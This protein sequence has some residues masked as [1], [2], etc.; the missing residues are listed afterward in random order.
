MSPVV[1]EPPAMNMHNPAMSQMARLSQFSQNSPSDH[2]RASNDPVS[3]APQSPLLTHQ[4][5]NQQLE[6]TI[7]STPPK[8]SS[9]QIDPSLITPEKDKSARGPC[10]NCGVMDTPLWRR[11]A[12]GNP[13]CNACGL[14]QK[15]RRM[16]R[17][18]PLGRTPPPSAP[19]SQ[20]A[21]KPVTHAQTLAS[22]A[23]AKSSSP[24]ANG[25]QSPQGKSNH[26][27]GTCPGDG[28]CDGTGGSSA[29]NGCPTYNNTLAVNARLEM[30]AQEG[31]GGDQVPASTT[32]G[33]ES[34]QAPASPSHPEASSPEAPGSPD[35]SQ[36]SGGPGGKK[37]RAAVG[38]LSCFNCATSTTPLWR[39]DDV[40]NNICNACGLYY[41]L[42]GTHRPGT[43]KK[44]VI[45][46]RKRVPAAPGMGGHSGPITRMTDQAAAEGLVS[47]GRFAGGSAPGTAGEESDADALEPP[48][49]RRGR[50]SRTTA[51]DKSR[52]DDDVA[53]EGTEEE[54]RESDRD[55]ERDSRRKKPKDG[56]WIEGG[57]PPSDPRFAHLQRPGSGSGYAGSPHL[58]GLDLPP[59]PGLSGD[60]NRPFLTPFAPPSSFIRSGSAAPSRTHS[61]M[62]PPTGAIHLGGF[63]PP[64]PHHLMFPP[65]V[66]PPFLTPFLGGPLTQQDLLKHYN[67]LEAYKK[68][69]EDMVVKTEKMMK[70]VQKGMQ[71]MKGSPSGSPPPQQASPQTQEA[72]QPSP[73]PQPVPQAPQPTQAAVVPLARAAAAPRDRSR[74][75]VWPTEPTAAPRE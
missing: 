20:P 33:L 26:P 10:L 28:R 22:A 15:S 4:L 2:L 52:E 48:K 63:L 44:T 11:D 62:G 74:E 13:L 18:S 45:K 19:A 47:L 6:L 29:C 14:Y 30:E 35:A 55:R 51:N 59:L 57:S 3:P 73:S 25:K 27:G 8:V 69:F 56:G 21:N 43:M 75:S 41:K 65:G 70:T 16:P 64:P 68:L 9:D 17:P 42:H 60:P 37:A 66:E 58:M 36:Q 5:E 61:P 50:K 38:A 31:Q 53:M 24:Q 67:E 34:L 39:R 12:D 23:S 71:D 54:T 49:K 40:G 1:L 72:Q 32:V 7:S 46:R